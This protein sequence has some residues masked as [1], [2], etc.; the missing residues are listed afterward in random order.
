MLNS[1]FCELVTQINFLSSF[2]LWYLATA[3]QWDFSTHWTR[4]KELFAIV[5]V[6][7]AGVLLTVLVCHG[8]FSCEL[9][10][11][12]DMVLM[13]WLLWELGAERHCPWRSQCCSTIQLSP[14]RTF[15]FRITSQSVTVQIMKTLCKKNL[16]CKALAVSGKF[17]GG[18]L[19]I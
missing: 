7:S 6:W 12:I 14:S 9:F 13:H 19:Y 2:L 1:S 5:L 4:R 8:K 16:Y 17:R 11:L 3:C 18:L 15:F 10:L